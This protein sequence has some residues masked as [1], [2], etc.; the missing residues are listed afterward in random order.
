MGEDKVLLENLVTSKKNIKRKILDMKRGVIDSDNY[1]RET[2]KPLLEPLSTLTEKNTPFISSSTKQKTESLYASDDDSDGVLLN[3]SFENFSETRP[4]SRRYDKSYGM[5][6]DATNEQLKISNIPV[7][8]SHGNL[9]VLDSYYPWTVGLWS[10][11]CEKEPKNTTIN[12]VESYYNILK[13]TKAHLK[14][15]GKPKTSRFFKWMNVVKPLY[16]RMKIEEN[17]LNEEISKIN[18]RKDKTPSR[19]N[20]K[21]FDNFLSS[22][23]AKRRNVHDNTTIVNEPFDFNPLVNSSTFEDPPTQQLFKFSLSPTDKK[24]SS[25]YKD[26]IPKTQLVYYDDPNELV[27]RLNLLTSSQNAGNTGVNN[28]II[29]I[30]E[31]LRERNIIE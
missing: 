8:V 15:D 30:L 12:D 5:Y 16:D 13:I 6:Y 24:G 3:S 25:L 14:A 31:E 2:F 17:Q 22:S 28:E 20:L 7:T 19:L 9:N 18:N 1:F 26:V 4:Q 29:S 11:L 23:S 10:L 21:Q 27:V